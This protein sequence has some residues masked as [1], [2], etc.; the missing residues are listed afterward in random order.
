MYVFIINLAF[1]LYRTLIPRSVQGKIFQWVVSHNLHHWGSRNCARLLGRI[2][3]KK[4]DA[5]ALDHDEHTGRIVEY[6]RGHSFGIHEK[7]FFQLWRKPMGLGAN[8]MGGGGG[9]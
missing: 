6:L 3:I 5:G 8:P 2:I 9:G 1:K 7:T 4:Y